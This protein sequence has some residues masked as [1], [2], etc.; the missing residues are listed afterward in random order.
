VAQTELFDLLV[1]G[2]GINGAGI[3]R[4]AAGRGLKV[5]LCEQNDLA[6]A[7]SSASSKLIHGG[8]RYLEQYEFRLVAEALAERETLLRIAPHL[9]TPLTFVLPWVP[10]MR[11]RWMLRL[12]LWL[13][14]HL[15]RRTLL[16]SSQALALSGSTFGAGLKAG[17]ERGF[18]YS[19]C[20][21]DDARLVVANCVDA[22]RR[23]AV[24]CPHTRVLAATRI[25][26]GWRVATCGPNGQAELRAR[27]LVNAAGPWVRSVMASVS[28]AE[29][30]HRIRL[31]K[32]S[33]I[34]TRRLYDGNHAFI[35]QNDDGRVILVIPY[36]GLY[37]L[38][39]TT[40]VPHLGKPEE[41]II[42]A[43][44]IAYLCAAVN[45]YFRRAI[46][47]ADVLWSFSGVRPL[48]D[49][50]SA[51]PS[52]VTRDYKLV[53]DDGGHRAP[54]LSIYGGKIT[55]YRRLAEQALLKLHP[56]FP[57]AGPPWTAKVPLPGGECPGGPAAAAASLAQNYPE[58]PHSLL[59]ALAS[60]H[61]MAAHGVLGDARTVADLGTHFG[62]SLYAREVD[63]LV[64]N[65]WAFTADDI[66]WRRT[67]AGLTL[68]DGAQHALARYMAARG[69]AS[70][71]SVRVP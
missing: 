37:S 71:P 53:V 12:G 16:P 14:D 9:V 3:A 44:E 25:D 34:V 2:G 13:Y 70:A 20:W 26:G 15:A 18:S 41:A 64:A 54:L 31:V 50:G 38:I 56:W 22:A 69:R 68:D 35:L 32:G 49:D 6:S 59:L 23:G 67:K 11:P 29:P 24:I 62:E 27:G 7:T 36:R 19:D 8:L 17:L 52:E 33:H 55:T 58:L 45:R 40:D 30:R 47:S 1:I 65:E 43:Q 39:G 4:D 57:S 5:V 51:N 42:S 48:Y 21:V 46:G 10:G 60:R 63:Y 61:G 66:L 28:G